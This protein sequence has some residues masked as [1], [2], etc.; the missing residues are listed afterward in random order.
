MS[1]GLFLSL[2]LSPL[3]ANSAPLQIDKEKTSIQVD[4]KATVGSFNG[5]LE[6]YKLEIEID[7]ASQRI[8]SGSLQFDFEY[9]E[10]GEPKRNRHMKDWLDYDVNPKAEFKLT[11]LDATGETTVAQGSLTIHGV[12]KNISFP[13]E[14]SHE[15]E[16]WIIDGTAHL[17][18][19]DFGLKKIRMALMITVNP[20]LDVLIHIEAKSK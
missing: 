3:L 9:L 2:L 18:Y 16:N 15:K 4:V 6:R 14:I 10:T 7:E 17:D 8:K 11:A 5:E 1:C 12:T 19:R 20:E 13:I